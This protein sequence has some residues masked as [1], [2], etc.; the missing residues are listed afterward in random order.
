MDNLNGVDMMDS[1]SRL[2]CTH[3]KDESFVN[4]TQ[5]IKPIEK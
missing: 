1:E 3:H 4:L 5:N 2:N